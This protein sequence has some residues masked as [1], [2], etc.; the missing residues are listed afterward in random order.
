[1]SS[2]AGVAADDRK[3]V[4]L[5]VHDGVRQDEGL[6]AVAEASASNPTG[7]QPESLSAREAEVLRLVARGFTNKVVAD[8]LGISDH[9]VQG[10]LAHVF[11]KLHARNRT[12]AVMIGVRMGILTTKAV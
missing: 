3:V 5:S 6:S 9:T 1:M 4:R 12:D 8:E 11:N 7:K 10:H 2:V